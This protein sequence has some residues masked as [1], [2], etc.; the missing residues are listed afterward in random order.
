MQKSGGEE[1]KELQ[2]IAKLMGLEDSSSKSLTSAL[3]KQLQRDSGLTHKPIFDIDMHNGR[4]PQVVSQKVDR[5]CMTLENIIDSMQF[6]GLLKSD[7]D[8]T[9]HPNTFDTERR[10]SNVASPIVLIKPTHPGIEAEEHFQH[11]LVQEIAAL[12]S[13]RK[14]RFENK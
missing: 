12:D 3:P 5:G 4:K 8:Q 9:Y 1:A 13:R 2:L 6:K 14:Q 7:K 10:L 11:Q